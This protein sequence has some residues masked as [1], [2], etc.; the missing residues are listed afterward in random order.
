[1]VAVLLVSGLG[2]IS[3][4]AAVRAKRP[5]GP[6]P[7]RYIVKLAPKANVGTMKLALDSGQK[8]ERASALAV[9]PDLIGGENWSRFYVFTTADTSLTT[10]EVVS[11]FGAGNIEY[12]EPDYYLEFF[13]WP[14]DALFSHQWYLNNTGQSYYAIRRLDGDN[15]D[16]Q[17]LKSGEAGVDIKIQSFYESPPAETV[18]VV[19]AIVDSGIDDEHPELQGRI[20]TNSDEVADDGVDN[21]HNGYIDDVYGYDISG[22]SLTIIY[23]VGDNDPADYEGHG[24][25]IAGIVAANANTA[26]VAGIA[27]WADVLPVKITPNSIVSVGAAGIMYAVDAGAQVINISWGSPFESSMMKEA[28]DFARHNGVFVAIAIGNTGTS[29]RFYPAAF[30]STF[31]V[32]A[33]NSDGFL[34]DFSTYG[35]HLDIVAPGLDI[36]SLR[37]A[38]TDMYAVAGEPGVRIVGA[39]ERYYL[40]DGTSFAAPIVAGAAAMLLSHRPDLNLGELEEILL[41]GADDM[42]DPLEQ[43]DSLAGFDTLSGHGYLNMSA[44]YALLENG[45][46]Y[47]VEPA[48]RNRYID[49]VVVRIAP[50]MGYTGSWVLD[51]SLGLGSSDWQ[52]LANGDELPADSI[53]YVF[54]NG[55]IEGQVSLRLTDKYGNW[56]ETAFTYV[57]NRKIAIASPQSGA[58]LRYNALIYGSAYGPDFDS[59]AVYSQKGA[60]IVRHLYSSTKEFFDSLIY[61]W[62]A[63]GSDT[64]GF[65]FYLHGYFQTDS[66]V[67]T[68]SVMVASSFTAGWPQK[69]ASTAAITAACTDL[70]RDGNR[71]LVVPTGTGLYLFEANGTLAPGYPVLPQLDMRSVPA[72]YDVDRDGQDEIICTNDSGI[73]AFK[74]DGS[75]ADG[76]PQYCLTGLI[77]YGY[78]YPNPTIA[79]FSYWDLIDGEISLV[80][81]SAVVIINKAGHILAYTFDG[82][83]YFASLGG[84]FTYFDT[85][86]TDIYRR[87]G[88]T[89]PFVTAADVDGDDAAEVIASYTAPAPYAGT[90]AF[91][92][93]NGEPAYHSYDPLV[94]N[95][96]SVFGSALGDLDGDGNPEIV[97]AGQDNDD[98]PQI[99]VN[100]YGN[101]TFPGFPVAMPDVS[102]WI[103][104]YPVIADLDLDGIPEILITFFEFDIAS[105]YIF[106]ADG[107]PYIPSDGQPIGEALSEP[108]TLGTPTVADVTGDE[109]PE[110]IIRSGYIFPGTGPERLYILDHEAAVLPGWPIPTPSRGNL[111]MSTRYAPLVDDL[112]GDDRVEIILVGDGMDVL[113]WDFDAPYDDGKNKARFLY[114]NLNSGYYGLADMLTGIEDDVVILPRT[115]NLYQN[116]PNPFNP[117][118][119]IMFD[120]PR[121]SRVVLEVF[122]ILGQRVQTVADRDFG[123]GKHM[124][125][126]DGSE[127]SSGV[128]FYRLRSGESEISRKMILV[129]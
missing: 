89:S 119:T 2:S 27:P 16:E 36:L 20:W 60:G 62:T 117:A 22:D 72:I 85:R 98:V 41:L 43:G 112:D 59:M 96:A 124:V 109:Y 30:D 52:P 129:K 4:L 94:M 35:P 68:V 34:A 15:N 121:R 114:D 83:S 106:R 46:L 84:L 120:L 26:G 39:D 47:F 3:A 37:A 69:V 51:Y 12:V 61:I 32:G 57:R 88:E 28:I 7:G 128:Y 73:Y 9:R 21:D 82:R 55:P 49:D 71:E 18:K 63:S 107:S 42:L 116:Y 1:M 90:A 99:W 115:V 56:R 38:G 86:A 79:G 23:V 45:G 50:V 105:L 40:G 13:D 25:H 54:S 14:E 10:S 81:D 65:N 78:G 104:S 95:I 123:A 67:D 127:F 113:V 122:N 66:V 74:Y 101:S 110:I 100:T 76:W 97:T 33:G 80:V 125:E 29:E 103:A 87:G 102:D 5:S 70:N 75:L 58:E 126:F 92:S 11:M 53:V 24:T 48:R 31:V 19:V 108:V 111:V 91:Q 6:V 8:L 118:T 93:K 64:G 77:P 17:I 44:S